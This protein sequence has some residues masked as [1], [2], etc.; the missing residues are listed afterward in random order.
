MVDPNNIISVVQSEIDK[1]QK[2]LGLLI[3]T[4]KE[5]RF[6]FAESAIGNAITSRNSKLSENSR[7]YLMGFYQNSIELEDILLKAGAFL[8][9]DKEADCDIDLS[10]EN[11]EKDSILNLLL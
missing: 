11:L 2:M 1:K 3:T 5:S 8:T 4:T 6:Y 7:K 10:P 9:N